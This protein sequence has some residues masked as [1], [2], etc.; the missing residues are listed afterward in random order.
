[1]SAVLDEVFHERLLRDRKRWCAV[2]GIQSKYLDERLLT[3]VGDAEYQWAA[4]FVRRW[5]KK[6]DQLKPG[7]IL[8]GH[9]N[10][11]VA[12]QAIAAG[13]LRFYIDARVMTAYS[14]LEAVKEDADLVLPEVLLIPNFE[15]ASPMKHWEKNR[16]LDMLMERSLN[17][18]TN[19]ICFS[20]WTHFEEDF[21][22]L[23]A[24]HLAEYD[25]IVVTPTSL[26]A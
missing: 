14:A 5:D 6:Q 20:Q 25:H 13:F 10:A 23:F 21:G 22:K 3:Y 7:L 4:N 2:A 8:T 24:S 18:K 26:T 17:G 12:V 19:V 9:D 11:L 16:L 1:M 15:E